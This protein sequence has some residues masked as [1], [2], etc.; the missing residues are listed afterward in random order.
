[1]TEI[2]LLKVYKY[3]LYPTDSKINTDKASV[4]IDNGKMVGSH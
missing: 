1:M 4:N 2:D 3:P